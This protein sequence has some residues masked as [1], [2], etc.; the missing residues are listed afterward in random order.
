MVKIAGQSLNGKNLTAKPVN[1]D[2]I[3]TA[4]SVTADATVAGLAA[5]EL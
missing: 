3:A 1:C 5:A 4:M 2:R